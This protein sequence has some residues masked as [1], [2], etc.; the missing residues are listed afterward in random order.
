M[1]ATPPKRAYSAPYKCNPT[2][3]GA[4]SGVRSL[5]KSQQRGS[6]P[7]EC[8][9]RCGIPILFANVIRRAR[10]TRS[11]RRAQEG[12]WRRKRA[13]WMERDRTVLVSARQRILSHP[14]AKRVF[15][16]DILFVDVLNVCGRIFVC[17][18]DIFFACPPTLDI[19]GFLNITTTMKEVMLAESASG[20]HGA[21]KITAKAIVLMDLICRSHLRND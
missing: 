14:V 5:V 20:F 19:D 21:R 18:S 13:R 7:R 6:S 2:H 8:H 15:C 4:R 12:I 3:A 11:I 9:T 10:N 16:D 17:V 1:G